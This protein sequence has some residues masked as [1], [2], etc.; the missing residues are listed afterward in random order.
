MRLPY[1]AQQ[2]YAK[3]LAAKA[4]YNRVKKERKVQLK[5]VLHGVLCVAQCNV[6]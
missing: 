3:E 6:H 2:I 4:V 5:Q 1:V